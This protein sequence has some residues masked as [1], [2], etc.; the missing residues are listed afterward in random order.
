VAYFAVLLSDFPAGNEGKKTKGNCADRDLKLRCL[1]WKGVFSY[2]RDVSASDV[3]SLSCVIVLLLQ[4][5]GKH[6]LR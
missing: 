5:L 2:E 4:P 6:E 1:V 3:T